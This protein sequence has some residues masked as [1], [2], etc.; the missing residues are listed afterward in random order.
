MP[1]V[2]TAVSF[3]VQSGASITRVLRAVDA[4]GAV[5]PIAAGWKARGQIRTKAG[6]HGTDIDD[7]LVLDL[8]EDNARCYVADYAGARCVYLVL[9]AEDTAEANPLNLK[10]LTLYIGIELYDDANPDTN[11]EAF[12]EGPF[13]FY[14]ETDRRA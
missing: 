14:S 2:P 3:E 9:N 1:A 6:Q 8:T 11:V 13:I 7:T 12:A 5:V 4:D 10:S